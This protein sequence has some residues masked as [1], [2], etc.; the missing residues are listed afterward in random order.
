[1]DPDKRKTHNVVNNVCQTCGLNFVIDHLGNE[2]CEA[3]MFC[4]DVV[5]FIAIS[6][7]LD[8]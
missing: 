6:G 7:K 4:S 3:N 2:F 5:M 8:R 1:M